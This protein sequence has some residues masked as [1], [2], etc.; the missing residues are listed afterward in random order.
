MPGKHHA[1][2]RPSL[3]LIIA[4]IIILTGLLAAGILLVRELGLRDKEQEAK[5]PSPA[6]V[7]SAVESEA[8]PTPTPAP[9]PS[10][11]PEPTPTPGPIPD[12][13]ED[14]YLSEGI[15]IWNSMAFELFYG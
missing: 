14:G 5:G 2:N 11:T 3:W 8:E 6:P 13:G 12:N 1:D 15:Y 9:T 4:V 7:S 10:P